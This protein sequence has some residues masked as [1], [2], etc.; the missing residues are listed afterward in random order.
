VTVSILVLLDD[1]VDAKYESEAMA[2]ILSEVFAINGIH[3]SQNL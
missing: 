1:D 2:M 3:K